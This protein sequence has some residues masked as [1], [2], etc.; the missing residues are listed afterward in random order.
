MRQKLGYMIAFV[1]CLALAQLYLVFYSSLTIHYGSQWILKFFNPMSPVSF[2]WWLI[3]A[4]SIGLTLALA[5]ILRYRWNLGSWTSFFAAAIIGSIAM[6][7]IWAT[8]DSYWVQNPWLDHITLYFE[9][10]QVVATAFIAIVVASLG[11]VFGRYLT[12]DTP[13]SP[14]SPRHPLTQLKAWFRKLISREPK[15]V[16]KVSTQ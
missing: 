13:A 10:D 2:S 12:P 7:F 6:P 14:T 4:M 3:V 1:S 11:I 9:P 5:I 8:I 15:P 16:L